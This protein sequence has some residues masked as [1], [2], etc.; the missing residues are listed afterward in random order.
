MRET[1]T[2]PRSIR[3]PDD[4]WQAAKH[5]AAQRGETVTDAVVRFLTRYGKSR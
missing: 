1:H 2:P 4:V 5:E 3:V